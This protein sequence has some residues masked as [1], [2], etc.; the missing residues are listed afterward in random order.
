MVGFPLEREEV[1][2]MTKFQKIMAALTA[3]DIVKDVVFKII[4]LLLK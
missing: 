2:L 4:D 3:A 1:I